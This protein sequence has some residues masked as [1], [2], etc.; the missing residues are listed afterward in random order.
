MRGVLARRELLL[1]LTHREVQVRYRQA[2]LGMAWA[3]FMPLSLML[4]FTLPFRLFR[5][6]K[7]RR[8]AGVSD[9][10]G[11]AWIV[12]ELARHFSSVVRER[13]PVQWATMR[14]WR[15]LRR[16]WPAYDRPAAA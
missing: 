15:R 6:L 1:A 9:P 10:G 14:R 4:V 5:Y 7:M 12:R 2:F 13:R 3:V 11:F 8:K 16:E